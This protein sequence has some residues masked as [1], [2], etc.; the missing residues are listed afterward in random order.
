MG[1][2]RNPYVG[3]RRHGSG[4]VARV[5]A[6][7]V[8]AAAL[9]A[10][11]V[12]VAPTGTAGARHY[13]PGPNDTP[14]TKEAAGPT[15]VT[16]AAAAAGESDKFVAANGGG[17]HR[18][19]CWAWCDATAFDGEWCYTTAPDSSGWKLC[20]HNNQC[21]GSWKCAGICSL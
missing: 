8:W 12:R 4:T 13:G 14:A 5:A 18:G 3:P 10:V 20:S 16:G 11:L 9:A 19:Y 1:A 15:V 6:A 21:N 17:C 7:T 2:R